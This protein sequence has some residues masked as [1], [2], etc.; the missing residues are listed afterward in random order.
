MNRKGLFTLKTITVEEHFESQLV[1]D[2]MTKVTGK[3]TVPSLS[4][5]M[6]T[7]MRTTLPTS[8][9]MQDV[10]KNRLNFMDQNDID[11][12]I[13]SYGNSQPQNMDPKFSIDICRV[14]NNELAKIVN[15]N[16][17]RFGGLA[18]FPVGDPQ[19]AATELKRVV[20]DLGLN[21]VLFKG[22]YGGKY[23]DDPFFLPIFQMA[24]DL[25]VPVY[26]H[27]S[28]IPNDIAQHYYANDNWSDVVTGILS[29]AGFGWH[30]DVGIQVMRMVIS[31]IFDKLPN[32]KLVSGHWGELIPMFLERLDDELTPYAGLKHPFS[33]YYRNNVYVTPSGILAEPQLRFILDEMGADHLLYSIDYPY[34]TPENSGTF[35][36]TA[37][38]TDEQ[39]EKIFHKNAETIFHLKGEK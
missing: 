18:V 30:M 39:R 12:Q 36:E 17:D 10:T 16:P 38:L 6:L 14:A 27:P 5:D 35:L 28:F 37:R 8:A 33:T 19:A 25:D 24:S 32:L 15:E 2:L 7:Y 9:I 21:G 13:L 29:S 22:N 3:P 34:K 23:F 26:F 20:E 1:T 11:M 31:G 4:E